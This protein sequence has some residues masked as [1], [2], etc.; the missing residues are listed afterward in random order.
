MA[1]Y[2]KGQYNKQRQEEGS[3]LRVYPKEITITKKEFW[4]SAGVELKENTG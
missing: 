3:N 2:H 1:T 4:D